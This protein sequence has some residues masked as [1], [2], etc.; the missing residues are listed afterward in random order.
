MS[1]PPR[2]QLLATL[3]EAENPKARRKACQQLAAS[4]DPAVIP[5]LSA[6][7][8]NDSDARVKAIARKGLARFRAMEHRLSGKG[9]AVDR[10]LSLLVL[11]LALALVASVAL[12]ITGVLEPSSLSPTPRLWQITER[13][14]L[15]V[16]ISEELNALSLYA[17]ALRGE[18]IKYGNTGQPDCAAIATYTPPGPFSLSSDD[19]FVYP[20]LA[21][22]AEKLAGIRAL[23]P[24]PLAWLQNACQKPEEQTI[25]ILQ[26]A[27][28]LDQVEVQLQEATDLLN[29]AIARPAPTNFPTNTPA[30]TATPTATLTPTPAPVTPTEP[31]AVAGPTASPGPT[32]TPTPALSPTPSPSPTPALPLPA[33]DYPTIVA[34]LRLR[35]AEPF[36]LDLQNPYGTGMLDQW[37][38]SLSARGQTTTNYCQLTAWPQAFALPPEQAALLDGVTAADAL[39]EEALRLQ[40][41]ALA[42]ASRARALYE[43]DCP[44]KKLAD[45]ASTGIALVTDALAKL[46]RARQF[47]DAIAARP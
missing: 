29:R 33:L 12:R 38:Q 30:P 26:A 21:L 28:S 23:L 35:L 45:S 36:L 10:F 41:E 19:Q 5:A 25:S 15:V 8:F 46:E 3:K 11:V 31:G 16:E 44:N 20:D 43:R 14:A 9:R 2:D 37:Q 42:A 47:V 22:L 27:K 4:G 34:E 39:L 18:T 13:P 24:D 40:A 6:A 7:Y 32:A 17:R 1:K